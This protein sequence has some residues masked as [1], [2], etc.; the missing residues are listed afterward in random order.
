MSLLL[1][2]A[3][4]HI[5]VHLLFGRVIVPLIEDISPIHRLLIRQVSV[6]IAAFE[7]EIGDIRMVIHIVIVVVDVFPWQ[8]SVRFVQEPMIQI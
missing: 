5:F 4:I 7:L 6:F 8:F 3:P 2:F 1:E